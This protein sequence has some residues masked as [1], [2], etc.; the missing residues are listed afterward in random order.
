MFG[1]NFPIQRLSEKIH[2]H[3]PDLRPYPF[4]LLLLFLS[5]LQE[6]KTTTTWVQSLFCALI[7]CFILNLYA[8][9]FVSLAAHAIY[10]LRIR[11]EYVC[12]MSV[13]LA[14]SLLH[15]FDVLSQ[16]LPGFIFFLLV[17]FYSPIRNTI[18]VFFQPERTTTGWYAPTGLVFFFFGKSSENISY[19]SR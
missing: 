10:K 11:E 1:I 4:L 2:D 12:F 17:S 15:I 6:K 3:H 18:Q 8:I 9:D 16:Q 13:R 7:F 5:L 19:M 14:H